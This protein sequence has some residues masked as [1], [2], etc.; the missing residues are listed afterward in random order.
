MNWAKIWSLQLAAIVFFG[1]VSVQA[2]TANR[3]ATVDYE[4]TEDRIEFGFQTTQALTPK[5]V[6]ARTDGAVLIISLTETT[7]KR[8]WLKL[9]D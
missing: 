2:K 4:G 8:H 6:S 7:V 5:N 9:K 1:A 3:L